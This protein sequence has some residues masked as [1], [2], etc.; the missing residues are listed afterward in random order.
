MGRQS[1]IVVRPAHDEAVP[2][3]NLEEVMGIN[4]PYELREAHRYMAKMKG[5]RDYFDENR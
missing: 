2:A 3:E 4:T 5:L 1:E